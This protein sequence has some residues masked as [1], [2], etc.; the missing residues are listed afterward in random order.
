MNLTRAS[1]MLVV[2]AILFGLL[3][4]FGCSTSSHHSG[5]D[6]AAADDDASDDDATGDDASDDDTYPPPLG[7]T[8]L[9]QGLNSNFIIDGKAREFYL[10]LPNGVADSWPWPVIFSWHGTGDT[11]A[12]WRWVFTHG[13]QPNNATMPFIG[14]TPETNYASV[15]GWDIVNGQ[16]PNEDVDLFDAVLAEIDTCWGVDRDRV[17][18]MGH[19]F[20]GAMSDLLGVLRGDQIASLGTHSGVYACDEANGLVSTLGNWPPL[21]TANKYAQL[22]VHG[23]QT[24]DIMVI[25]NFYYFNLNDKAWLNGLGHDVVICN[26]GMTHNDWPSSFD[27][28]KYVEFFHD[29]PRGVTHSPYAGGLPA[30]YPSYCEFSPAQ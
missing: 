20:G 25:L 9:H 8:T 2:P 4:A 18:S 10:D 11:A 14:V 24:G 30:D 3:L 17:Y 22:L 6:D 16:E 1:W 15:F 13:G 5:D 21:T 27:T 12:N 19:S 26:H 23:S 7:C 28:P 29:H